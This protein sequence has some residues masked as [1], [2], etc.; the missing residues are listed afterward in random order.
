VVTYHVDTKVWSRGI[1]VIV[2]NLSAWWGWM[3]KGTPWPFYPC[4]GIAGQSGIRN[5][6]TW[7]WVSLPTLAVSVTSLLTGAQ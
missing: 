3:Y 6:F 2:P 5:L 1:A 4:E 7:P